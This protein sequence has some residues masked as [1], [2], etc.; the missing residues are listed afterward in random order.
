M[1]ILLVH[2]FYQQFGGEDQ[3]VLAEME[4]LKKTHEV[5]FYSRHNDELLQFG[6][7]QKAQA[8]LA[9]ISSGTTKS[10]IASVV[11][12]FR[13]DIAFTHNIYPLISPSIYHALHALAVPIVQVIHDFRPL[14]PNGWFFN[15][16]GICE[17]CKEGNYLHAIR[18]KC[19]KDSYVYSSL[20]AATMS[21]ARNSGALAK[22][23]AFICLTEF[24]REKL[25]SAGISSDRIYIRPNAIDASHI[26]PAIGSGDYVAFIGRLSPEKGL[27]TL[28][29]A[30]EKLQGPVL[31]IAGTGPLEA[32]IREYIKEKNIQNIEMVGF[33]SGEA[34][35]AF[36]RNCMFTVVPSEWY[37]MFPLVMLEAWAAGKP[38]I[39]TQ[40]G[41]MPELVRDGKNGLLFSLGD[42]GDLADKIDQLF[43]A[44]EMVIQMGTEARRMVETQFSLEANDD[45]L[46]DIFDRVRGISPAMAAP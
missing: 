16:T 26:T 22:V 34:K 31:K 4:R 44:P 18:Y 2:N 23:D 33:I 21:Y 11:A 41:A 30:F 27:W 32:P 45:L 9:T 17:R 38:V 37:E 14:C 15:S 8:A 39:T 3:V 19:Y 13:P 40:L 28:V 24:A 12:E 46:I 42:V 35:T 43:R 25:M 29:R 5:Y 20:Y 10:Q 7:V 36:L 1:R 6:A